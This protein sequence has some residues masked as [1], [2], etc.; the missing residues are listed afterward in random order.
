M[1]VTVHMYIASHDFLLL[2]FHKS[3]KIGVISIRNI[4]SYFMEKVSNL[5]TDHKFK[6]DDYHIG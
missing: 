6:P 2:Q 4:N 1:P 5:I 3:L